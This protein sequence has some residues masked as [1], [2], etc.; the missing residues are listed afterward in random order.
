MKPKAHRLATADGVPP[1][2]RAVPM[3][4]LLPHD[5]LLLVACSQELFEFWTHWQG[6]RTRPCF[7]KDTKDQ[8]RGCEDQC[9]RRWKG[10]VH[11]WQP[12]R[13]AAFFLELTPLS[14]TSMKQQLGNRRLRGATFHVSRKRKHKRGEI[15]ISL[16]DTPYTILEE[17]PKPADPLKTLSQVWGLELRA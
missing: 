17:L 6:G 10:L 15:E 5:E 13:R 8:C 4:T 3:Y 11:V 1:I 16:L 14:A 9:P 2:C 7:R 12:A